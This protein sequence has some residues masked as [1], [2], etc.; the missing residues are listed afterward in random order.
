MSV[1]QTT[2]GDFVLG[3]TGV[4]A[5]LSGGSMRAGKGS[6]GLLNH[7]LCVIGLGLLSACG[8]STDRDGDGTYLAAGLIGTAFYDC[9]DKDPLLGQGQ[10]FYLDA[11]GDL[12]GDEALTCYVCLGIAPALTALTEQKDPPGCTGTYVYNALDCR[13]SGDEGALWG[14]GLWMYQDADRDGFGDP[15]LALAEY[16]CTD[17]VEVTEDR[18]YVRNSLDCNDA[19]IDLEVPSIQFAYDADGDGYGG[20]QLLGACS[21]GAVPPPGYTLQY[22]DCDDVR[23]D[24]YPGAPDCSTGALAGHDESCD[25]L[26]DEDDLRTWYLDSD[27]DGWGQIPDAPSDCKATANG[28]PACL[29]VCPV[30]SAIPLYVR[31]SGDCDDTNPELY[32]GQSC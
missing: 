7:G 4:H 13:D 6:R 20:T 17:E 23:P 22:G 19:S 15:S 14:T 12:L 3:R 16:V 31:Q 10:R 9:D 24:T 8:Y 30:G 27:G 28:E 1:R 5:V 21:E 32:P 18:G 29:T 11:D 2:S 26:L 25:G